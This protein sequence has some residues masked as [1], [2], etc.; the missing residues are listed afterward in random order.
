MDK[1]EL[2]DVIKIYEAVSTEVKELIVELKI[3]ITKDKIEVLTAIP[4][5]VIQ[6][7]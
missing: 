4:T 3:K 5:E 1:S 6:N 7:E 2:E